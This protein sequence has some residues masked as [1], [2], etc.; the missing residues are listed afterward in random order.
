MGIYLVKFSYWLRL[1]KFLTRTTRTLM[2]PCVH[3][4]STAFAPSLVNIHQWNSPMTKSAM[5]R[6]S[7]VARLSISKATT[8]WSR[9][10]DMIRLFLLF[11]FRLIS[12]RSLRVLVGYQVKALNFADS[13]LGATDDG[14]GV[15]TL[16]Q[17][18]EYYAKNQPKKTVVFNIN[19]GEEDW[20]NGAHA[21]VYS[22]SSCSQSN[23]CIS[24]LDHPWSKLPTTFLNLEGAGNGG[25]VV[26]FDAPRGLSHSFLAGPCCSV[27]HLL[28][29]L[30]LFALFPVHMVPHSLR[31]PS[32]VVL[33]GQV[34]T[35][36]YTRTR[37]CAVWILLSIGAGQ[38][39]DCSTGC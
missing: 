4:S 11:Y 26:L 12:T 15:V 28:T 33:F 25:H 7:T 19:N 34:R 6:I 27:P 9:L 32:S 8:Y 10:T 20:L 37:E 36:P 1:R 38:Y 21:C 31:M 30:R 13:P 3:T 14:M 17:L 24:F 2:K 22:C 29:S 16:L 5:E 18:V 23:M 35:S 39:I